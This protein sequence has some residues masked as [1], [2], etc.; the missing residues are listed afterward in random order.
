MG[1]I[2]ETRLWLRDSRRYLFKVPK[3]KY[4]LV[5]KILVISI[6]FFLIF[7]FLIILS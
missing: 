5:D 6:V 2:D 4:Q 3:S 7:M 1:I